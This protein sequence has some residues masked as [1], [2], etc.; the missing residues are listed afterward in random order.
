MWALLRQ[1]LFMAPAA[2]IWCL[3]KKLGGAPPTERALALAQLASTL[4]PT[5][6]SSI[7]ALAMSLGA[8][9]A[10]GAALRLFHF[11]I[12]TAR[13][14]RAGALCV[15]HAPRAPL[16]LAD[17]DGGATRSAAEMECVSAQADATTVER[18][19]SVL[20]AYTQGPTVAAAAAAPSPDSIFARFDAPPP[21]LPMAIASAGDSP[22]EDEGIFAGSDAAAS[23]DLNRWARWRPLE[24]SGAAAR[25]DYTPLGAPAT[26]ETP[27]PQSLS[28]AVPLA[29]ATPQHR[30]D[31][32]LDQ[33]A[34]ALRTAS[35]E[36]AEA[37]V[38]RG[39]GEGEGE[40]ALAAGS[41]AG[42]A[43]FWWQMY[44]ATAGSSSASPPSHSE[45]TRRPLSAQPRLQRGQWQPV[46]QA[47]SQS[48]LKP[49]TQPAPQWEPRA[50]PRRTR[51]MVAS[52]GGATD[53]Q[54]AGEETEDVSTS[55]ESR[56]FR[57]AQQQQ[58]DADALATVALRQARAA[59]AAAVVAQPAPL[60]ALPRGGAA[61]ISAIR[62]TVCWLLARTVARMF[63]R[64]FI[65]RPAAPKLFSGS[66]GAVSPASLGS[67]RSLSAVLL[68]ELIAYP[69]DTVSEPAVSTF[70]FSR[71]NLS[72]SPPARVQARTAQM[73]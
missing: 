67:W 59:A 66:A 2:R 41:D 16:L 58:Q 32:L 43:S 30:A 52:S 5:S 55:L 48:K 71:A 38:E 27:Q 61:P 35:P 56:F 46:S 22:S 9:S 25:H 6:V 20:P 50:R 23:E 69:L 34:F 33:M 11:R 10:L 29:Q 72:P 36:D 60:A 3:G 26:P 44:S 18:H 31:P 62:R 12:E 19:S 68:V 39:G 37:V 51:S 64:R 7:Q 17:D 54:M 70:A 42:S 45:T 40:S 73:C 15:A 4:V 28:R 1:L 53:S 63:A 21:P 24:E 13:M 49:K 47:H 8:A 65:A 14:V 57:A